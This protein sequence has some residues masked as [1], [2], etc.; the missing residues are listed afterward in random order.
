MPIG[1]PDNFLKMSQDQKIIGRFSEGQELDTVRNTNAI[2]ILFLH[3][4]LSKVMCKTLI[5]NI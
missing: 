5:D 1:I 3:T 4:S 2:I